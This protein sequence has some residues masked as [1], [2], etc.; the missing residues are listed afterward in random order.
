[1]SLSSV[2]LPRSTTKQIKRGY[3][4][5]AQQTCE[6]PASQRPRAGRRAPSSDN[7]FPVL[8]FMPAL[9]FLLVPL[10][11]LYC[12]ALPRSAKCRIQCNASAEFTSPVRSAKYPG[13][14]V[15]SMYYGF[16]DS[17]AQTPEEKCPVFAILENRTLPLSCFPF[18]PRVSRHLF[19]RSPSSPRKRRETPSFW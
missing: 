3:R 13:P 5:K 6:S 2:A 4:L 19:H 10:S 15:R 1:M 18:Y 7:R 12:V 14:A 16:R 17:R 9:R 11:R 8:R